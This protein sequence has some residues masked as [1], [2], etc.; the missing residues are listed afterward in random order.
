M[1]SPAQT[2]SSGKVAAEPLS[3]PLPASDGSAP[4]PLMPLLSIFTDHDDLC[5]WRMSIADGTLGFSANA[6]HFFRFGDGAYP[7]TIDEWVERL[8]YLEDRDRVSALIGRAVAGDTYVPRFSF[9]IHAP[10]G[11]LRWIEQRGASHDD[12]RSAEMVWLSQDITEKLRTADALDASQRILQDILARAGVGMVT[13]DSRG[14]FTFCNPAF[15]SLLGYEARELLGKPM[16]MLTSPGNAEINRQ[17][18]DSLL[19]QKATSFR[20]EC[21]LTTKSG[22]PIWVEKNVWLLPDVPERAPQLF[23]VIVSIEERRQ[24]TELLRQE[25]E[26]LRAVFENAD[27]GLAIADQNGTFIAMNRAALDIHGFKDWSEAEAALAEPDLHFL[28][29]DPDG[30]EIPRDQWPRA[31]FAR[32]AYASAH[33]VVL[34]RRKTGQSRYVKYSAAPVRD[35]AGETVLTVYSLNDLTEMRR[36]HEALSQSQR[37]EALGRLA[38]GVAHD[39]NNVLAIIAGNLELV[40]DTTEDEPARARIA[41]A[42]GAAEAGASINQRL[43]TIARKRL[44]KRES[45]NVTRRIKGMAELLERVIGHGIHLR[46]SL[47]DE[48][49]VVELDPGEFDA[50]FLNLV[51][52]GRDA[53][54]DGGALSI[55]V[56][57]DPAGSA[58]GAAG[59]RVVL[60]VS[61]TGVGMTP[62]TLRLAAEPFF[63]TKHQGN[64]VG[65]GLT[66]VYA[67]AN[68]YDGHVE[69]DSKVGEGTEVR[70]YLPEADAS[71]DPRDAPHGALPLG[72][73]ELVLVVEDND[74]V[75]EMTCQRIVKL[76]YRVLEARTGDEAWQCILRGPR[77]DCVF[78]DVEMP[79]DLDGIALSRRL[80]AA[81]P[82][83]AVVLC[84]GYHEEKVENCGSAADE[85]PVTLFKPYSLSQLAGALHE[86]VA[87]SASL[88][89]T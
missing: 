9:R 14:H 66:G 87:A 60:T 73:G 25:H 47:P 51:T 10:D 65:L 45:V 37:L 82:P 69:I 76:G 64:G 44:P 59:R 19:S 34:T 58:D 40:A 49:L 11:G 28:L 42:L 3:P 35:A 57:R 8:V 74:A 77:P 2:E 5:F 43:L 48:A 85:T 55:S 46:F 6:Q 79:G 72:N 23:A 68:E 86:A 32:G 63:T 27:V 22:L 29:H 52:N 17:Q 21:Q 15:C 54:P 83:I 7:G 12:G 16:S 71:A 75:R 20:V 81:T 36:L 24:A 18:I 39:F 41:A 1:N 89:K 84:T 50:A 13:L 80:Q 67:F 62:E 61:D 78:S 88:T 70:I 4:E 53:M 38:G 26:K 56:A 31:R 33:D 30:R